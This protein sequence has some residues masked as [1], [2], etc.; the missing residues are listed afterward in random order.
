MGGRRSCICFTELGVRNPRSDLIE[1]LRLF[2]ESPESLSD[3]ADLFALIGLEGDDASDF[4]DRF[5][6]RF[7]VDANGYRWYFHHAEEGW[8]FGGLFFAPPDQR[9]E[10][11]PIT[12]GILVEAIEAKQWALQYPLHDLPRVRWDT[13]VN[14]SLVLLPLAL[15]ALWLWQQFVR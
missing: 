10:R 14:Q 9:V 11:L 13:R 4:I 2:S 12:P 3:D 6:G 1:F 15:L 5:S 7:G 8:N